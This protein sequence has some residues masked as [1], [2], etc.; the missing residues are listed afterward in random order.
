MNEQYTIKGVEKPFL[1]WCEEHGSSPLQVRAL[2]ST[3]M[4]L[5]EALQV[6]SRKHNI[7]ITMNG[8]TKSTTAW[9]KQYG[10]TTSTVRRRVEQGLTLQEAFELPKH[11][12]YSIPGKP[13]PKAEN[14]RFSIT[15][16]FL[17]WCRD[18]LADALHVRAA[19]S[20][21]YSL[22]Y[23]LKNAPKDRINHLPMKVDGQIDTFLNLCSKYGKASNTIRR[24]VGLGMTLD[25]AFL[26]PDMHKGEMNRL[27]EAGLANEPHTLTQSLDEWCRDY[28]QPLE[29]VRQRLELGMEIQQALSP[30]V[31]EE[32]EIGG[33]A[34]RLE[35]LCTRLNLNA[36]AVKRRM[37]DGLTILEA[38]Y[39]T[40]D[41]KLK[42]RMPVDG[43]ALRQARLDLGLTLGQ[44]AQRCNQ[45][46]AVRLTKHIFHNI[47]TGKRYVS[48]PEQAALSVVF[49]LTPEQLCPPL[50]MK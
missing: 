26:T 10:I 13:E 30:P 41:R 3:G 36:G 23:A 32:L 16:P 7:L 47:E 37:R 15:K 45:V 39:E 9:C 48:P 46:G 18:Y 14:S 19:M 38:I 42:G 24:R 27:L 40:A 44:A 5:K 25:Q 12:R 2:M 6:K 35:T 34:I 43:V 21:G 20:N 1:T 11:R 22:A 50:T 28:H 17:S 29:D 49:D 33:E 31:L 8:E 4:S